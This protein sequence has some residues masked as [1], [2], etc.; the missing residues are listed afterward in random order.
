MADVDGDG[1]VDIAVANSGSN[2]V[3]VLRNT[4]TSGSITS[5][6]MAAKVDYAVASS[7]RFVSLGDLDGD[8]MADMAVA[9]LAASSI[10]V[11]RNDPLRPIS[12]TAI[13]CIGM[14]AALSDATNGGTWSSSNTGIA[15]VTSTGIVTGVATGTTTITYS[16]AGGRTTVTATVNAAAAAITGSAIVC[17]GGTTTLSHTSSGGTWGSTNTAVATIGSG[18]GVVTGVAS[19]STTITYTLVSGC[20]ITRSLQVNPAVA[21]ITGSTSICAGTTT[22]LANATTGGT[23]SSGSTTV[24]SVVSS[25][26]VVTGLS[27]GTATITYTV[28]CGIATTVVI[29]GGVPTITAIST[30][31]DTVL[32]SVTI[33]GTSFNTTTTSNIVYFGATKASVTAAS[34]TSLTVVVPVDATH[35][36]IS[37]ENTGC[38]LTAYSQ[39]PFLPTYNNGLYIPTTIACNTRVDFTAGSNP[40]NIATGDIDGDGN[41]DMVATNYSSN[42]ISVFRNTSTSGAITSGSF[43]AKVDFTTGSSPYGVAI[44]DLDRD[45]KLDI[46][47]TNN[48]SSPPTVSVFR[49]TATSGTIGSGSLAAKVDLGVSAGPISATI[50]DLDMDGKPDIAVANNGAN[51]ISLLRNLSA[52]GSITTASFA[53]KVDLTA[54]SHP[55]A[56]VTGDIDGDGKPE[57]VVPNQAAAS[58]SVFRNIAVPGTLSVSSFA[59]RVDFTTGSNP[60]AVAIADIDG[61]GKMDIA[62]ANNAANSISVFRQHR[63]QRYYRLRL[64]GSKG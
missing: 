45:G 56:V 58:V 42:T 59:T 25:T 22:T 23:W 10:S 35:A 20:M 36:P 54:G 3:S 8:G 6:S 49:N 60:F 48:T 31:V 53:T 28:A 17:T 30:S 9:N 64:T 41:A 7:P 13:V 29:V 37:V 40:F 43:A 62:V 52:P 51:T 57:L 32:A 44:G 24:A 27:N 38:S 63:Y 14:T 19:G 50:A 21:A 46:V 26:G 1:K 55:Y 33:T 5:A 18:T 61:D 4:A 16:V 11:L 15:T 34:G 47:V 2:T 12:G 39:Y